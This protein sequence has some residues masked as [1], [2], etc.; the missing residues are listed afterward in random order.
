[1]AGSETDQVRASRALLR[2]VCALIAADAAGDGVLV[3]GWVPDVRFPTAR[4]PHV[5]SIDVDFAVRLERAAH[6]RVVA[7]LLAHGF[8]RGAEPYQFIK[9]IKLPSGRTVPARLDLLTSTRHHVEHFSSAPQGPH[10]VHGADLAFRDN[11]MISIGPEASCAV[12]VAGVTAFIAMKALALHDRAKAKDAYDLHFFLENYPDGTAGIS[13]EFKIW[14]D[15][16]LVREALQ[17][18]ATQ[19]RTDEDDGPRMVVEVEEVFG[20]ARAIRKLEVFTRVQEFLAA[21]TSA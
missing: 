3:G 11:E 14:R 9:D 17:K 1:M 7:R 15:D 20:E 5:G 10:P 12:R 6:E 21:V 8:R 16:P 4:P 13:A 18:L 19:F 2:E